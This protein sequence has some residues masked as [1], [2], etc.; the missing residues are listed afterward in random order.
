MS[1]AEIDTTKP[2]PADPENMNAERTEWASAALIEFRRISGADHED[3]LGDLLCDLMHWSDRNNFDFD[4]ALFR[5]QMHYQAEI[6]PEIAE[7]T[8]A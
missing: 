5:A 6:T 3:A 2:L 7:G 8:E 1:N 4:A